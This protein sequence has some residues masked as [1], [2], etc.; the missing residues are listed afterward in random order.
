MKVFSEILN[1]GNR[2]S[3]A[4]LKSEITKYHNKLSK[5]IPDICNKILYITNKYDLNSK[6]S[7][8][9]IRYANSSGLNNI[10]KTTGIS[11]DKL[12][13][14]QDMLKTIKNEI[15][16]LPQYQTEEEREALI[17]GDI[18]VE[19][20][21]L[22][23][24][25]DK[26]RN[27]VA[28]Q[29]AP[30]VYKIVSKYVNTS[31][32]D[33]TEL[34]SA[35]LVGLTNAM[36]TYRKDYKATKSLNIADEDKKEFEKVRNLSF[37]TYAAYCIKYQI[38]ADI[39]EYSRTVKMSNYYAN[40]L[41]DSGKSSN[42]SFSIDTT[43]DGEEIN[44][45]RIGELGEIPNYDMSEWGKDN[46]KLINELHNKMKSKFSDRDI[47]IFFRYFGLGDYKKE[48][49]KDIARDLHISPGL[50]TIIVTKMIDVMKKDKN[51]LS[52]LSDLR[53]MYESSLIG[54]IYYKTKSQ[55][56]E[57][58]LNDE[59]FILLEEVNK[60]NNKKEFDKYIWSGLN[61]M[62]EK[63]RIF[64]ANC[65]EKGFDYLDA[66]Y[67]KNKKIIIQFLN[68]LDPTNNITNKSDVYILDCMNELI[69]YYAF[70]N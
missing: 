25:T 54:D 66:N 41:K 37:K 46:V 47:N 60:F 64:I 31:S 22:D 6:D 7:L 42:T 10:S 69:N 19:D 9:E 61:Y 33:K 63:D 43:A 16:L 27:R 36:N 40:K 32:L 29:Y 48:K 12:K 51:M 67:R 52:L 14:L 30:L 24:D 57:S 70:F 18:S 5:K 4:I 44:I 13:D 34:I 21:L 8:E 35:G 53:D 15:K 49:G 11:I 56:I 3:I 55:I 59:T 26:G 62:M 17:K 39:A 23:L 50:V 20:I 38:L 28:T 2:D 68:N 45:D 65:I 1:E 58:L